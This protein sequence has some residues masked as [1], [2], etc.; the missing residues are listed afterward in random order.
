MKT[1][2][3]LLPFA[4]ERVQAARDELFRSQEVDGVIDDADIALEVQQMDAWLRE[5]KEMLA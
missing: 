3:E 4:I 2:A 5:A 1:A